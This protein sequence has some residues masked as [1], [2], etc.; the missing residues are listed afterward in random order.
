MSISI[1]LNVSCTARPG[2]TSSFP[3]EL[4][5]SH[6]PHFEILGCP[7]GDYIYCANFIASKRL[8]AR[9]LLLS[10]IEVAA[11]DLQVAL[12]L[13]CLCGSFSRLSYLAHS[14]PTNLVS[15]AFKLFDDDIHPVS[16]TRNFGGGMVSGPAWP[17]QWWS[18][19]ALTVPS[20]QLSVY[21][22]LMFLW[23]L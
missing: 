21:S 18:R 14:T 2:D 9:K 15:D 20:L 16:W 22:F 1:S 5:I 10:L 4:N 3:S 7:I 19:V 13:L 17:Q 11:I 8:K 23:C 12:T 6:L